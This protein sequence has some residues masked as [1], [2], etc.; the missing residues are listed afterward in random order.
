[1]GMHTY[2]YG[3]GKIIKT[4][5]PQVYLNDIGFLRGFAAFDFFRV[6][7]K[8]PFEYTLHY[9]RLV[10]SAK[11]I[12]IKVPVSQKQL[13]AI[14][15]QLIEKNKVTNA[16]VRVIVT[17]GAAKEGLIPTKPRLYVIFEAF[18]PMAPRF[19]KQGAT[20]ITFEHLRPFATAK[21]TAY[22]QA[23]QLQKLKKQKGAVEV[24]YTYKGNVLEATTSNIFV[25]KNKTLITPKEDIL[26]GITRKTVI[27]LAKEAGYTVKEQKV[28]VTAL[29]NADEV[30][31]TATNKK[32]LPITHVDEK[33]I[34]DGQTG[35]VSRE[36]LG[37]FEEEIVKQCGEW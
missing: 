7:N 34:A 17:G 8:T 28:S 5:K 32:V 15:D 33:Q 21:T 11:Q 29:L 27:R 25:V 6:Y 30:F 26:E 2:A 22:L 12:G 31:L 35:T 14:V 37:L 10:A 4:D 18:K 1:M 16:H 3:D 23:V 36:L 13:R 24:L 20:L 19:F 9:K